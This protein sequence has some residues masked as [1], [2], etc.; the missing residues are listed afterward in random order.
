MQNSEQITYLIICSKLDS[1]QS[2]RDL[3]SLL[4]GDVGNPSRLVLLIN[5][6]NFEETL[7]CHF[8]FCLVYFFGNLALLATKRGH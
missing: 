8:K 3:I 1:K 5:N 4:L 2:G 6:H 7:S